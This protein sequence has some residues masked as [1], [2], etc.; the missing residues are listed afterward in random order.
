V[1][2]KGLII[3]SL[4]GNLIGTLF[5]FYG[6]QIAS[7]GTIRL[8]T[9]PNGSLAICNGGNSLLSFN[10][11]GQTNLGQHNDMVCIAGRSAPMA[12]VVGEHPKLI[13]WGLRIIVVSTV[14]ALV[15]EARERIEQG[16]PNRP[17]RRRQERTRPN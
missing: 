8:A 7:L 6:L 13:P 15:A 11:Y 16:R 3:T 12:V 14:I 1:G 17:E 4:I 2:R 10:P 5:L 9:A